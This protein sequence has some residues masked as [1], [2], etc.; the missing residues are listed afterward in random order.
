M[1]TALLGVFFVS[2]KL[3]AGRRQMVD[4]LFEFGAGAIHKPICALVGFS[5]C[6]FKD[7]PSLDQQQ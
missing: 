6:E 4:D 5:I 7:G 1:P 2:R 3:V